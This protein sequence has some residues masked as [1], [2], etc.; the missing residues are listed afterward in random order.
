MEIQDNVLQLILDEL[1]GLKEGQAETNTRLSTLES[2][3]SGLKADMT[4]VKDDLAQVKET[5]TE[6]KDEL[7]YVWK[8]I[9]KI[10]ER[11][12]TQEATVHQLVK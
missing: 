7:D 6:I 5:V 12:S 3:V 11:L 9:G 4:E 10:D 8:D 2:D 1:K